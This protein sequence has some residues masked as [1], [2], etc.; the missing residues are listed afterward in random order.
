MT[1]I[2]IEVKEPLEPVPMLRHLEAHAIPGSEAH[3]S[4]G[5]RHSRLIDTPDGAVA[6][7]VTIAASRVLV[8]IDSDRGGDD[9]NVVAAVRE[10][11]DLDADVRSVKAT[12]GDDPQIG[13][14][15][16]Q[17]PGLR[18]VGY[19]DGFEGAVMTLLGQQVSLAAARTFGGRLVSAFG[20]PG[21]GGLRRFP[22]PRSLLEVPVEELRAEIGIT[23]ARA[24][25]VH[26]VAAAFDEGLSLDP[27]VDLDVVKARLGEIKGV[28]PW[29]VEYLALRALRDPDAFPGGDLVLRRVLGGVSSRDATLMAEAWRPWRAYA[30]FHLWTAGAFA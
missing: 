14:L 17:R 29:T 6:V 22:A 15:I 4:D 2:E 8:E 1:T 19:P 18:V 9:E 21:P 27:S 26:L 10:W 12:L 20:Q 16:A 13:P 24:N 11:L 3:D 30:V 7:M 5:H 28:G 23:N 25:T